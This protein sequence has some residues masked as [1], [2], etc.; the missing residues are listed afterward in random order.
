VSV[1]PEQD[2]VFAIAITV[3]IGAMERGS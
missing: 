2:A 1:A 3:C